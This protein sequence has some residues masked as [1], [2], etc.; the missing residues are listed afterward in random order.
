MKN[1]TRKGFFRYMPR[2]PTT[3]ES[4]LFWALFDILKDKTY[5]EEGY[6]DIDL[7]EICHALKMSNTRRSYKLIKKTLTL[8][9]GLI[10]E[11]KDYKNY[12]FNPLIRGIRLRRE[13]DGIT[14]KEYIG[15]KMDYETNEVFSLN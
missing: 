2:K 13:D 3:F 10:V 12:K 15:I 9:C 6:R 14:K 7:R 1:K 8:L 4:S 11:F 5:D